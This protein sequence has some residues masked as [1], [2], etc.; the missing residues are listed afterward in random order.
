MTTGTFPQILTRTDVETGLRTLGLAD[1]MAIEV[2]S[3]LSAFGTVDGGAETVIDAL[4]NVIGPD[5]ALVM[6]AFPYSPPQPLSDEDQA[7]G[8]VL[9]L[10][11]LTP[12]ASERTGMG[13]I[14]DTFRRRP[15]V[16]TGPG[17]HRTCAWGKDVDK[18]SQS[19]Q[20]LLD[21]DGWALL[22]G[23]DIHSLST[24]HYAEHRAG[25]VPAGITA[26]FAAGADLKVDYPP[27]KWYVEV[28]STPEDGWGKIQAEAFRRGLIRQRLIGSA[29]CLLFRAAA[30]TAIFEE[31]LRA[32]PYGLFGVRHIPP[33]R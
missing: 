12:D 6:P 23:V 4:M 33:E 16:V 10:R 22:L 3:S 25:G 19:F 24:M 32:D 13:V 29:R 21:I 26:C 27:D 8:I 18:H 1:G 28:G 20:H 2:H 5:G 14:A 9:K 31:A 7:R 15:D 11:L 17:F 30:V